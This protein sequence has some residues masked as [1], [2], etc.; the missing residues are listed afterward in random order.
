MEFRVKVEKLKPRPTEPRKKKVIAVYNPV[1]VL[2][3]SPQKKKADI[4]KKF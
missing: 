2:A 1:P 3:I 4:I